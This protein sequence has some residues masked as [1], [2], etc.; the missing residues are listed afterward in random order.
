MAKD[1]SIPRGVPEER[2]PIPGGADTNP[3][4]KHGTQR[5]ADADGP[6]PRVVNAL[7]R[8]PAGL[9]RV[10]IRLNNYHPQKTRYV[11]TQPGEAGIQAAKDCVARANG[12]DRQLDRLKAAG[13]VVEPPDF[14]V[15]VLGD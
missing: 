4:P 8:A 5:P 13:G 1:K 15:T 2:T 14:V 6:I 12:L 10:K 9:V 7:D 11:L 3:L